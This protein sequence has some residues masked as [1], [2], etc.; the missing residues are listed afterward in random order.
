[1]TIDYDLIIIGSTIEAITAADS[2]V[3]LGARVALIVEKNGQ[4]TSSR[5]E[6]Y[7]QAWQYF[8]SSS[9]YKFGFQAIF[10]E[11]LS[12]INEQKYHQLAVIGV[13]V[14][15]GKPKFCR[16]P[17][18]ALIVDNR[19]ITSISYLIATSTYNIIPE[20]DGINRINYLTPN[21]FYQQGNHELTAQNVT[22][23]GD[24]LAAIKLANHLCQLGKNV[25]LLASK[26]KLLPYEDEEISFH[27][28]A[29]LES[30][31]VLVLTNEIATQVK[32]FDQTKWIQFGNKAIETE[33]IVI[34]T[35]HKKPHTSGLNLEEMG[36]K[37]TSSKIKVNSKLQTTNSQIYA[38]GDVIGGHNNLDIAKYEAKIAVKNCLFFNAFKVNY[39]NLPYSLLSK[40][41]IARVGLTQ[42]Q[43]QKMYGKD[44]RV[45]RCDYSQLPF[46]KITDNATGFA[47]LILSKDG[48]ILG[49]HIIGKNA[50][51]FVSTIALAKSKKIKLHQ[52]N[53]H[54]NCVFSHAEIIS[55]LVEEWNQQK[56]EQNKFLK[57]LLETFFIWRR[58]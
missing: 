27:L 14:I 32:E 39:D 20:I 17:K 18:L 58:S 15:F 34:A 33:Q 44:I 37:I 4:I 57:N 24:S 9:N 56:F 48:L 21:Y 22:I 54:L 43:A 53:S 23:I 2:A 28:Q 13:D 29:T 35:S 8:K 26:S 16:L 52:I 49:C 41:E 40:P 3:K 30:L 6:V 11:M 50:K 36:V 31:G 19:K 12:I 25:T 10:E 1:M 51:E 47:K 55:Q 42:K 38:I 5:Q 45:I 7:D 46:A